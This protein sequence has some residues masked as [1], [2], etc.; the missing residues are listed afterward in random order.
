[1]KVVFLK[2]RSFSLIE[3]GLLRLLSMLINQCWEH[4]VE[5]GSGQCHCW[6]SP[7]LSE[8]GCH[9][10]IW[11]IR[12]RI[13]KRLRS[14]GFD[15][16]RLHTVGWAR[17]CKRLWNPGIDFKELIA[18]LGIDG[19]WL[20]Q[21]LGIDSWVLK[22]LQIRAQLTTFKLEGRGSMWGGSTVYDSGGALQ[23]Y[24]VYIQYM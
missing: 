2:F 15:S 16:A 17:I 22:R 18:R 19:L 6:K 1:M 7:K 8:W 13:C 10:N 12:A 23:Y 3:S 11:A 14:P 4:T 24:S 9:V 5:Y 20:N 21:F